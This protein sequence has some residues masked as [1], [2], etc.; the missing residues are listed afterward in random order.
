MLWQFPEPTI[1]PDF[2]LLEHAKI[3][4]KRRREVIT[5]RKGR[6]FPTKKMEKMQKIKHKRSNGKVEKSHL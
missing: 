4:N 6:V 3:E 1:L 5:K 2:L